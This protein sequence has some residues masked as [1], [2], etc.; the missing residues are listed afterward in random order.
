M[1]A[2]DEQQTRTRRPR[3]AFYES[4]EEKLREAMRFVA[5]PGKPPEPRAWS[6]AATAVAPLLGCSTF[7][8][9][10]FLER[11]RFLLDAGEI[12]PDLLRRMNPL[13]EH[14]RPTFF[15]EE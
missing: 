1:V 9:T 4:T 10:R 5:E 15:G 3:G 11:S 8:A 2:A 7:E 13:P 14:R 12:V 6:L